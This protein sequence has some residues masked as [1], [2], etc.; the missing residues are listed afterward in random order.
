M[1]LVVYNTCGLAGRNN[2][3]FYIQALESILSQRDVEFRLAISS[4]VN[5]ET[6][7]KR[8]MDHFGDR[9]S[10]NWI[11]EVIPVNAT[12]NHTVRKMEAEY[13]LGVLQWPF[14]E[15]HIY[16]DSGIIFQADDQLKKMVD[17]YESGPYGMISV[18]TDTDTGFA[19]WFETSDYGQELFA[20]NEPLI[21]PIG[22]AINLHAQIFHP[23]M[24][25]RWGNVIPDIFA[26][27]CTESVF[28]FMCGAIKTKWAVIADVVVKHVTGLDGA[29]WGFA[30]NV[31]EAHGNRRYDHPFRIEDSLVDRM[32]GGHEFGMGY[33]ELQQIVMHDPSKYDDDGYALDD[34]LSDWIGDNLFLNEDEFDYD[35]VVGEF[36]A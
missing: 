2:V 20:N 12:F 11:D 27:Q 24:Y 16:V 15:T 33:E 32:W 8:L 18:R 1:H 23:E 29:S 28:S 26:G 4:C 19:T 13:S 9:V 34:R 10:Y 7:R 35:N 25:K 3:D 6:D 22:R 36:H 30:P 5:T 31:W 21:V 14:F 17:L